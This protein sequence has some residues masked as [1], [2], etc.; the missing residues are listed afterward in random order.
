MPHDWPPVIRPDWP[1]P[2]HVSALVTTR[3]GGVSRAP[4][5]RFNLAFH[6]GDDKEDV[7]HNREVLQRLIG[8]SPSVTWIS[9]VHGTTIVTV[10]ESHEWRRVP[11]ADAVHI[12]GSGAAAVMTADCLPVFLVDQQGREAMV[13]HAG[14]RG[15]VAGILQR[16]VR[17]MR[18]SPKE[19]MAWLGPAIGPCHFEVGD[20]VRSAFIQAAGDSAAGFRPG[21]R[22]GKWWADLY[23]LARVRLRIAGIQD[24]YGG[25]FC[26]HCDAARFY[27]YRRDRTTGRMAALICLK[28][29]VDAGRDCA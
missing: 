3:K 9:Q 27:S 28:S 24:I 7:S 8:L 16:S 26:T 11:E 1:A 6:V 17:T 12:R 29:G 4:F 10:E 5:D 18:S 19:L 15:M 25:G 23:E 2:S 22:A 20:E 21:E 13:V 14:W